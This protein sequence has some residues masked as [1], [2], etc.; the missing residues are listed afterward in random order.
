MVGP[1]PGRKT[2]RWARLAACAGPGAAASCD[3]RPRSGAGLL[4]SVPALRT[5][6][7]RSS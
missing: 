4:G 2:T 5:E 6:T 3:R 7:P 1:G